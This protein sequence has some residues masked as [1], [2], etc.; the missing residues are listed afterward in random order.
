MTTTEIETE[1][2][3]ALFDVAVGSLNFT[4]GFLDTDEVNMLR[5]IAVT[6]GV[7]PMTATPTQFGRQYPHPFVGDSSGLDYCDRC[8]MREVRH[9]DDLL[10]P[11]Y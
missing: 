4:S 11:N 9:P 10:S 3:R 1:D 7:D 5:R 2:L 8:T 6:L